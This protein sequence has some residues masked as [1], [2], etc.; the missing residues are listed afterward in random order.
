MYFLNG[1][2]IYINPKNACAT[3]EE[4]L[5]NCLMQLS[6]INS[7]KKIF[8]INFFVDTNTKDDYKSI[9]KIIRKEVD[10][11]FH[12]KILQISNTGDTS[13]M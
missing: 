2:R 13:T 1:E 7:G 4:Q 3:L 10:S 9:Q 6:E 5:Q 8:K 12:N 11:Q